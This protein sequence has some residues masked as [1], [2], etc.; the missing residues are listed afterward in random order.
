MSMDPVSAVANFGSEVTGLIDQFV[1]D[2]DLKNKLTHELQI[3]MLTLKHTLDMALIQTKTTPKVDAFV[4]ILFAIKD[5][6]IPLFRPVGSI[7]LAAFGGYCMTNGVELSDTLQI[8]LFGQTGLY[9]YSRHQD[10][11]Q[12]NQLKAKLKSEGVEDFDF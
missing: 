10:K 4:K 1:E 7:A 9:G 11:K 5:I 6:I 3:K 12:K 2:K 8:A